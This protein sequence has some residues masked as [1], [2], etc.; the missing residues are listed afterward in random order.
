MKSM[1]EISREALEIASLLEEG[2]LTPELESQLAISQKDL[3]N[4]AVNYGYVIKSFEIDISAI[5]EEI[6]RLQDLK[7]A[8]TNACERLKDTVKSAMEI[9]GIQ[10][11]E[12]PTMKLSFRKSSPVEIINE[13]QIG[14]EFKDFK[15][16]ISINKT[17]IKKAIE[18]G[19]TVYGAVIKAN[20]N[21]Q[22]K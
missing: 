4:K 3:Q 20:F 19:E 5:D 13:S 2:E 6:K 7:K 22:V 15:T 14:V 11:V 9:Y 18:K 21:L 1:Y 17:R 10:K 8:K 12:T 16:S